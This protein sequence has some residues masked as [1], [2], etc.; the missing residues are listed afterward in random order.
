M[1]LCL[2]KT[3]YLQ[4]RRILTQR[5]MRPDPV[6]IGSVIV[7]NAT[8]LR[9]VEHDEVIEAFAPNRADEALDVAVVPWRAWSIPDPHCPNAMGVGWTECSVTVTNHVTW[10]LSSAARPRAAG[11]QDAIRTAH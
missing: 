7:Q 5:E 10:R 1:A 2:V 9:F 8:H 11:A 3:L 6:V 4:V